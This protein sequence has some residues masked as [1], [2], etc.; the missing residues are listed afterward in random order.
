MAKVINLNEDIYTFEEST[1]RST[2]AIKYTKNE[3]GCHICISHALDKDGYPRIR[4]NGKDKRM[5][6][7]IYSQVNQCEIPRGLCVMHTCD[8]PQ[9]INPEHLRLG[10]NMDNILD[11][12]AKGR[13]KPNRPKKKFTDEEIHYIREISKETTKRL[14]IKFGV[15]EETIRNIRKFRSHKNVAPLDNSANQSL[16]V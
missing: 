10:T 13:S 15:R 1:K 7:Y 6:R 5:S 11:K 4:Q 14:A 2:N 12:I 16:V 9:C 8:N 3:H